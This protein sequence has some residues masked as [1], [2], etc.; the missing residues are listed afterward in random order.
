MLKIY[1]VCFTAAILSILVAGTLLFP[2]RDP[3]H[4]FKKELMHNIPALDPALLQAQAELENK[5]LA[6]HNVDVR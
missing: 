1:L 4:T 5:D 3:S 2:Q 6:S